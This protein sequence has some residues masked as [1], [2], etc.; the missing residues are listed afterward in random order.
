MAN[1]ALQYYQCNH[2]FVF[3]GRII[4]YDNGALLS[5]ETS[6][7]KSTNVVSYRLACFA[8][9][10]LLMMD[11]FPERKVPM[12]GKASATYKGAIILGHA[13]IGWMYCAALIGIGSRFMSMQATLFLH[14]IGAPLG[15]ALVSFFYF[16]SFSYTSP[17]RTAVLF[18]GIIIG[19]DVFVVALIIVKSFAMFTN[20]LGTWLP[21]AL[22]FSAT[23]LTGKNTKFKVNYS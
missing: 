4:W 6:S 10:E 8:T 3:G 1:M 13:L 12:S 16:R 15:F 20:I 7:G 2:L 14:A 21:F 9:H 17:L 18:L 23:Y 19:I 11:L 22:I 5:L